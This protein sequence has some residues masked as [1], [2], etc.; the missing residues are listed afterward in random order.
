VNSTCSSCGRENRHGARFCAGCGTQLSIPDAHAQQAPA[1][2]S[3]AARGVAKTAPGAA[4]TVLKP[5]DILG[6]DGRYR[7]DR[8]LDKGGFGETYVAIDTAL[9]RRCVVKRALAS[10]DWS[11]ADQLRVF[12]N[13]QREAE[14]LVTLNS[15]GH[16]NI[17]EI[18]EYLPESQ[19]LIMKYIEGRSLA[20]TLKQHGGPLP[21]AEALRYIRDACWAL[22]YMHGGSKPVLHRDIKPSNILLGAD[23]RVWLIDFGLSKAIPISVVSADSQ[24]SHGS[25]TPGYTPVEQWRGQVEP[26][27]DVYALAATLHT[28][29][30]AYQPAGDRAG[31]VA[32]L[33]GQQDPLPPARQLNPLIRPTTEQLVRRAMAFDITS[34]PTAREFLAE[35]ETLL[36]RPD[37][38]LPP[39]PV[40]PPMITDFA[41]RATEL[42][43]F[44]QQLATEHLVIIS[45]LSGMGKTAMA[46]MLARQVADPNKIFWHAFH[47][48]EGIN[49]IIWKLAAFLAWNGQE[50]IWLML[51]S[52][53][54]AGGQLPPPDT[55]LD[56]LIP[57]LRGQGY[58]LCLDD[59]QF[60]EEDPVL[61]H[62]VDRLL[63]EVGAGQVR[64]IITSRHVPDFSPAGEFAPLNGLSPGDV[65]ELLAKRE[66]R[67]SDDVVEKLVASTGGNAQLLM[68]SLEL[69]RHARNPARRVDQ[70]HDTEDIEEFLLNEVDEGLDDDERTVMFA[71]SVMLGYPA[72]R[73][74]ITA[75]LEPTD[76]GNLLR[77]DEYARY[78]RGLGLLLDQVKSAPT[79]YSEALV[80]Q[81]RLVENIAEAR[82][83]GDT[84]T[85]EAERAKVIDRLNALALSAIGRSFSDLCGLTTTGTKLKQITGVRNIRRTLS[86]LRNRNLLIVTEGETGREYQQHAMVRTF[87]YGCL[88]QPE[89]QELHRRAGAYY[90]QEPEVLKA[91]QHFERAAEYG[92]AVDL[93]SDNELA[94]VNQGQARL[95][96]QLLEHFTARQ[97]DVDRWIAVVMIRGAMYSIQRTRQKATENFQAAL[98]LLST[99]PDSSSV[100]ERRAR[101]CCAMG[102]LLRRTAPAEALGWLH[103]G[104]SALGDTRDAASSPTHVLEKARLLLTIGSVYE[105][106]GEH[107][108][109]AAA[110]DECLHL[111]PEAPSQ[112]RGIALMNRG[113]IFLY[114]GDVRRARDYYQQALSIYQQFHSYWRIASLRIN[115]AL[116]MDTMGDWT[117]ATTEYQSLIELSERLGNTQ[118]QALAELNLGNLLLK[119]GDMDA[120]HEH[121]AQCLDL[122]E[123]H[124]LDDYRIAG[125]STLADLHIRS[126]KWELAEP[127]LADAEQLARKTEIVYALPEIYRSWAQL[128]LVRGDSRAALR[129]AIRAL[130]AARELKDPREQGL[131]RRVLGQA[132]F[133]AGR[134]AWANTSFERTMELLADRD[135]Y[136]AARTNAAWGRA[137]LPNRDPS[138]GRDL[139]EA[140]RTVFA[141]LGARR[142]LGGVDDILGGSTDQG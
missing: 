126:G 34:R 33:L 57:A 36:G 19:C 4:T 66:L 58:L 103:Q 129:D 135:P 106:K 88:E 59:F 1:V 37:V 26:R 72:T 75:L 91:A 87:Y 79:S 14:L 76:R 113:N 43:L 64:L 90:E 63:V 20:H 134:S 12:D 35:L 108:A 96:S 109:A 29:L 30:T 56:Y 60:V 45:G 55:L 74:A 50:D 77:P 3:T 67:L 48:S 7:I 13:F 99:L 11:A 54:K 78:E 115:L 84:D 142:D 6:R 141:R 140:A 5:G 86:E 122:A 28:L 23:G 128:R 137:L 98:T 101:V 82:L 124:D 97:L 100:R 68:L 94:L 131:S 49:I 9:E 31:L 104:L 127:L 51:Q 42:K 139:L 121:L 32:G 80:Y 10:P 16:P 119:Q 110:L 85:Y 107:T 123:K 65:R 62:F 83:Y 95:V 132:L 116:A 25:G 47:K 46:A 21:E 136:E 105:S 71:L 117:Q 118:D 112:W 102:E 18:Y 17:P 120:A 89:L 52:A 73:A 133:G 81:Q 39:Q 38:P 8:L 61:D 24:N 27:S 22:V 114:E 70:L 111:L 41:G 130:R 40:S 15:P 125:Q 138:R 93:I 44:S 69:L 2:G 92:H 53:Q